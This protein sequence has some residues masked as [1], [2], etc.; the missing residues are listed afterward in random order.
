MDGSYQ[1]RHPKKPREFWVISLL[2]VGA[3]IFAALAIGR[4]PSR[5][6]HEAILTSLRA[7]DIDRASLQRDVLQARAG[8][9]RNYDPLVNSVVDLHQKVASL[10]ALFSDGGAETDAEL[11]RLLE[12]LAKSI[13][14]DETLVEKFKTRNAL[15][16]NSLSI[17]NQ[18][19]SDLHQSPYQEMQNALAGSNDLG[20]LMMRYAAQP[21]ASLAS[22]IRHQFDVLLVSE[23]SAVPDLTT[24]VTHGRE[25]LI[26][27]PL[28]DETI[29][30]VQASETPGRAQVLQR[31]YL[32]EFGRISARS[33]WSRIFLASIAIILCGHIA[34]LFYRLQLQTRRLTQR[35]DFETMV[36]RLKSCFNEQT[37]DFPTAME[38]ALKIVVDF[39]EAEQFRFFLLNVTT[40]ETVHQFGSQ[41]NMFLD[42]VKDR[43][44]LDQFKW[45]NGQGEDSRRYFYQNLVRQGGQAFTGNSL[46][47]GA[48]AGT[49]ICGCAA[50]LLVLEYAEP[51]VK[52]GPDDISFLRA[53]VYTLAECIEEYFSRLARAQLEARLEHSQR[54]E[55]VGTL[56][57]GIAHEF[58]NILG[59]MLGYGEMALQVSRRSSQTRR[60]VEEIVASGERAKFIIDQILTFSRKRDRI[61]KPFSIAEAIFDISPLLQ[62]SLTD[63]VELV[64]EV[65]GE[66]LV[67]VGNPIEV[68]QIIM[69]LCKNAAQAADGAAVVNINVGHVNQSSN[70]VLSHGDLTLG[71]YVRLTVCDNGCGIPEDV[72]PHIFEP[73]FTTKSSSG[74]TGL[75]LA[76]V[77]GNIVGMGGCVDVQSEMGKGTRFDVYFPL[78]GLNPISLKQF[79]D[80]HSVPLGSGETVLVLEQEPTVRLMYEEKVAALGYEPLGFGNLDELLTWLD[81]KENAADLGLFDAST[82]R[83]KSKGSDFTLLRKLPVVVISERM[84]GTWIDGRPL[85]ALTTLRK[86]FN[87]NS[88]ASAISNE[89]K[90]GEID[91]AFKPKYLIG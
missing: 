24:L 19:L 2:V 47:A 63:S 70:R 8:L 72:L 30:L 78:S 57:G 53:A 83:I 9:L 27:L 71:Q 90:R 87:S 40:G 26:T 67:I 82:A 86:P 48:A 11:N 85:A 46:S 4:G 6:T 62:I 16:Q 21:A 32:E 7:I 37:N 79:F 43:F 45:T 14:G 31:H 25:I 91:D 23:A 38:H 3:F 64:T 65:S 54:L 49:D 66:A 61:T 17:F 12:N 56:A 22:K 52:P 35:L 84:A 58:N 76:A 73:F 29:S 13:N 55:A 39:F 89:L 5:D 28:V 36:G 15:L 1:H 81:C 51:K 18:V 68:Q 74:G 10:Q 50:A 75:G 69:N 33:S 60:Y 34:F 59:A 42:R 44:V 20:N 80:E 41:D 77:H 88:L